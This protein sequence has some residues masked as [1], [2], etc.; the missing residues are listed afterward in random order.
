MHSFSVS[1]SLLVVQ[2]RAWHLPKPLTELCEVKTQQYKKKIRNRN[3]YNDVGPL[4]AAPLCSV[5]HRL[6]ATWNAWYQTRTISRSK[7]PQ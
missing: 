7:T 5:E 3:Q 2:V 6:P 4:P 1:S